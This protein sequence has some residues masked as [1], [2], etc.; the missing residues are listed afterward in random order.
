MRRKK[1]LIS[2]SI[3]NGDPFKLQQRARPQVLRARAHT[4]SGGW[5]RAAHKASAR[6]P[7]ML[8]KTGSQIQAPSSAVVAVA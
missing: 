7:Q 3:C 2:M 6:S 4:L 5:V 1:I 8:L